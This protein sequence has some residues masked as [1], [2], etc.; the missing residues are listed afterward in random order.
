MEFRGMGGFR[1]SEEF[2]FRGIQRIC[3][4]TVDTLR[5]GKWQPF[6]NRSELLVRIRATL[7]DLV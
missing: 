2:D 5:S 4:A 1:R 3:V 6:K 7:G